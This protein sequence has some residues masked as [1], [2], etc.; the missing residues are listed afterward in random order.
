MIATIQHKGIDYPEFQS[1]GFA[2]EF[3]F[4]FAKKVCLGHGCDIG[5]NREEWAFTDAQGV[6]AL[7]IDKTFKNEYDAYNLPPTN[8]DYIFSSHCLEHL[9]DWVGALDYWATKLKRGGVLFLYLPHPSQ[10]YWLPWNNRKHIHCLQPEII[11]QYLID[12]G[13]NKIFVTGADL[14]NSFTVIAE[15][16]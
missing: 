7:M 15:R 2:A 5:C 4:P 8:F 3:A 1:R 13:W 11:N 16:A 9:A 14:N 6:P 10:N 12:K